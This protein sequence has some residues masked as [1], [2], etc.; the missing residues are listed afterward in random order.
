MLTRSHPPPVPQSFRYILQFLRAQRDGST[1]IILPTSGAEVQLLEA[2][3]EYYGLPGLAALCASALPSA[4]GSAAT[5]TTVPAAAAATGALSLCIQSARGA[6]SGLEQSWSADPQ[7]L[8]MRA[9]LMQH[10]LTVP[11][12]EG[13]VDLLR[14]LAQ[15]DAGSSIHC[16]LRHLANTDETRCARQPPPAGAAPAALAR[17]SHAWHPAACP[18]VLTWLRAPWVRSAAGLR[19]RPCWCPPAPAALPAGRRTPADQVGDALPA[20]CAAALVS[21]GQAAG[22]RTRAGSR[23]HG[24]SAPVG[25][26]SRRRR[27]PAHVQA[28]PAAAAG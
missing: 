17:T 7:L 9:V 22:G 5:T 18:A 27:L 2:E 23:L 15:P 24:M 13:Q 8:A 10:V 14:A 6:W 16:S 20:A 12:E 3:A 4:G 1:R 25:I 26:G 28:R 21:P 19:S 11:C